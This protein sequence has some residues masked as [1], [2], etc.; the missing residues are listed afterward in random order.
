MIGVDVVCFG[1]VLLF[2]LVSGLIFVGRFRW[3]LFWLV[4]MGL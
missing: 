2:D 1:L 4:L 3:V